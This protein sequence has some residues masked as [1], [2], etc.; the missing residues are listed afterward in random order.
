LE[1]DDLDEGWQAHIIATPASKN[2][3]IAFIFFP[4]SVF[5]VAKISVFCLKNARNA[6]TNRYDRDWGG[7]P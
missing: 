2:N 7:V 1:V 3:L 5:Y 4:V 6:G